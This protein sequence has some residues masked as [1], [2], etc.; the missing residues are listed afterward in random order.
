LHQIKKHTQIYIENSVIKN[1]TK[2]KPKKE[3]NKLITIVMNKLI[4]SIAAHINSS[5]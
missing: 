3:N 4:A 2:L 5:I 1:K